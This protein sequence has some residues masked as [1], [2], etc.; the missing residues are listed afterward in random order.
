[1]LPRLPR[2]SLAVQL[3]QRFQDHHAPLMLE[4]V[5]PLFLPGLG[6]LLLAGEKALGQVPEVF[7]HVPEVQDHRLHPPEVVLEEVLQAPHARPRRGTTPPRARRRPAPLAPPADAAARPAPPTPAPAPR[8]ALAS[9]VAPRS[10]RPIAPAGR[11][12]DYRPCRRRP[13]G[14]RPGCRCRLAYPRRWRPPR[15]RPPSCPRRPCA[16]PTAAW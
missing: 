4:A 15:R 7:R 8:N 3:A 13:C 10:G 5:A 6:R 2:P 11:A 1:G 12:R 9:G 14:P 16:R